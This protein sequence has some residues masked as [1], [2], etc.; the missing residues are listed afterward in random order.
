MTCQLV[1]LDFVDAKRMLSCFM[2]FVLISGVLASI[3]LIKSQGT[4]PTISGSVTPTFGNTTTEFNFTANYSDADNELGYVNVVI[5]GIEH[6]M[7]KTDES[8]T[9]YTDGAFFYYTCTL[10]SSIHSYYFECSDGNTIVKT[11]TFSGPI[12]N[13]SGNPWFH[14]GGDL[15]YSIAY[16]GEQVQLSFTIANEHPP[17]PS[18]YFDLG[19][20][21]DI[22]RIDSGLGSLVWLNISLNYS[23]CPYTLGFNE[24]TITLMYWNGTSWCSPLEKGIDKNSKIVWANYT[25]IPIISLQALREN[26]PPTVS[27]VNIIPSI[28]EFG[29]PIS[30]AGSGNDADGDTIVEYNWRSS[31]DGFIS[32]L[33]VF[34]K[35]T[36][37]VGE[38]IIYFKVKDSNGSWSAE[39]TYSLIITQSD[40]WLGFGHD[41][42]HTGNNTVEGIQP[43][44]TNATIWS[45]TID[46]SSLIRSQ[47]TV[48][49]GLVYFGTLS[50]LSSII[51]LYES[52]GSIA[53][54][55]NK[56]QI[57]GSVAVIGDKLYALTKYPDSTLYCLNSLTGEQNWSYKIPNELDVKGSPVIVNG[58]VY[59]GAYGNDS[60]DTLF[61]IDANT[62]S[63]VW[64]V[65]TGSGITSTVAVSYGKVIAA[66]SNGNICAYNQNNGSLIWTSH[67]DEKILDSSP[68]VSDGIIYVGSNSS[69]HALYESNGTEIW[70]FSSCTGVTGTATVAYDTVYFS[71]LDQ[72]IYALNKW[73]GS[74]IWSLYLGQFT[75]NAFAYSTGYLYGS[76]YELQTSTSH[77]VFAINCTTGTI[78]WY[79]NTTSGS[80]SSPSIAHGK[81]FVSTSLGTV[82]AFSPLADLRVESI[83]VSDSKPHVGQHVNVS[84][85]LSNVG[86]S[87]VYTKV[88]FYLDSVSQPNLISIVNVSVGTGENAEVNIDFEVP[89][90]THQIIA[91]LESSIPEDI[92]M[93]NDQASI[94]LIS[95]TDDL[96]WRT[97]GQGPARLGNTIS[98]VPMGNT[99]TWIYEDLTSKITVASP[100]VSN[101]KVI[102]G[103][104]SSIRCLALSNGS[105]LWNHAS[106]SAVS[107]TPTVVHG[108]IYYVTASG[109]VCALDE[110][111]GNLIWQSR[112]STNALTVSPLVVEGKVIVGG[113]SPILYA[114]REVDGSIA[115]TYGT[116]SNITSAASYHNGFAYFGTEDGILKSVKVS[117]GSPHWNFSS[118]Q[119]AIR[120]APVIVD[121]GNVRIY[122][123]TD[124]G[125]LLGL[126]VN[127][128]SIFI[129][130]IGEPIRGSPAYYDGK[131]YFASGCSNLYAY[132]IST[133]GQHVK[134]WNV[135]F[136]ITPCEIDRYICASPAI[137]NNTLFIGV[138]RLY[139]INA[140]TG[141]I[142]WLGLESGGGNVTW[143]YISPAISNGMVFAGSDHCLYA[144]GNPMKIPPSA[145]V[146]WPSKNR[147]RVNESITF[148]VTASDENGNI[149]KINWSFGDGYFAENQYSLPTVVASQTHA[150]RY[151]GNYTVVVTVYDSE[152]L[153]RS[154]SMDIVVV[155]NSKPVLSQGKAD[156]LI[157][158][159][160]DNIVFS[161]IY[162]DADNDPPAQMLLHI[163]NKSNSTDKTCIMQEVNASD[164]NFADGKEYYF[165]LSKTSI[166]MMETTDTWFN[167][168]ASD[169]YDNTT[170][171]C[172]EKLRVMTLETFSGTLKE[173]VVQFYHTG[174]TGETKPNY[175]MVLK[176]YT[177]GT[178]ELPNDKNMTA[179]KTT[180]YAIEIGIPEEDWDW[181]N[182]SLKYNLTSTNVNETTLYIVWLKDYGTDQGWKELSGD[183]KG[184]NFENHTVWTNISCSR[185]RNLGLPIEPGSDIVIL[186]VGKIVEKPNNPPIAKYRVSTPRP[187]VGKEVV[188]YATDSYD[189]DENDTPQLRYFW[190]F[191]GESDEPE[192][193]I[194]THI[195]NKT[196]NY[197]VM[198][199]VIDPAGA[200]ST[201]TI[202]ITV[203]EQYSQPILLML[204]IIVV[205]VLAAILFIP[206]GEK[207]EEKEEKIPKYEEEDETEPPEEEDEIQEDDEVKKSTTLKE[208]K[209]K[210]LMKK[211]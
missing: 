156:K 179:I 70:N 51:A 109:H 199:T 61:A 108:V 41:Q 33:P 130:N 170:L 189:A 127:G 87:L 103:M 190:H 5:D 65:N 75:T 202:F 26:I 11:E 158:E 128:N 129:E 114:L 174:E 144:Y 3:P 150:Y 133:E 83:R 177:P 197:S 1:R 203:V 39:E 44:I 58:L 188:F 55:A 82:T 159:I 46:S 88:A 120:S 186:I 107:A 148:P 206:Y 155:N 18:N 56:G 141:A 175:A 80:Q 27:V 187:E 16:T 112:V 36:L 210:E 137:A 178:G 105:L 32:S 28:S 121:D 126:D 73:T 124:G 29:M 157:A 96:G 147:F 24:S 122:F 63:K 146:S 21:L 207:K 2:V 143:N 93:S 104:G 99:S 38:H 152:G 193:K 17:I 118:G 89:I 201:V 78:A 57:F 69:M 14:A 53:W 125:F 164:I 116:L 204:V 111:D 196:G 52:N 151:A 185:A 59:F 94:S 47:P 172:N 168:T 98:E 64:S 208:E 100:V 13:V 66:M 68:V 117:D 49:N 101:G 45:K 176:T 22:V 194:I 8:D 60:A 6:N 132:D 161:V 115:W 166:P 154:Y 95:I 142:N 7:S 211:N 184:I 25:F 180:G 102:F 181:M 4:Q 42:Y 30:F 135:S 54:S 67:I 169:G 191:M 165:T 90:G 84:A 77:S 195:F 106:P 20:Y 123:G 23:L 71:G 167:F 171:Q 138:D 134:A 72:T 35:R 173:L 62:G 139:S 97:L 91:R 92:N 37:S 9:D 79:Y 81:M 183:N 10:N 131:L 76:T 198:L 86:N 149:T 43:P 15:S 50:P 140:S 119:G 153:N 110:D 163:K 205:A 31:I 19:L 145:V 182:I 192:G 12:M 74:L 160:N 200:Q 34:T 48:C 85:I 209:K 113:M 40:D 136:N 162:E